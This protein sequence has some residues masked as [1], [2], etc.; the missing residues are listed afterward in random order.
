ME[1]RLHGDHSEDV[2][3]PAYRHWVVRHLNDV[4]QAQGFT[5]PPSA[6]ATTLNV[7]A[8]EFVTPPPAQAKTYNRPPVHSTPW[9][10]NFNLADQG[11]YDPSGPYHPTEPI[12]ESPPPFRSRTPYTAFDPDELAQ[13]RAVIR[14]QLVHSAEKQPSA[15]HGRLDYS[16]KSH[17]DSH[18]HIHTRSRLPTTPP[19]NYPRVRYPS[20]PPNIP[21]RHLHLASSPTEPLSDFTND[22]TLRS[23]RASTEPL[24]EARMGSLTAPD[25]LD[26]V[27]V[28]RE[29]VAKDG[30]VEEVKA[31]EA[32]EGE[33]Q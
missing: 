3:G 30:E 22:T 33:G 2:A 21:H 15:F 1:A 16:S 29:V 32:G 17:Q 7:H 20:T 4:A 23:L 12:P 25:G 8:Q 24:A 5:S 9:Y 11:V 31:K 18:N 13:Y 6:Q 28:L 10:E 19:N 27:H 14:E 26:K